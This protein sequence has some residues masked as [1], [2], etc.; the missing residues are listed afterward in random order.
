MLEGFFDSFVYLE[1]ENDDARLLLLGHFGFDDGMRRGPRR[2]EDRSIVR[3]S[4]H[5][6]RHLRCLSSNDINHA[7]IQIS[8]VMQMIMF[9][10]PPNQ[11]NWCAVVI[12]NKPNEMF[13]VARSLCW[14]WLISPFP[15]MF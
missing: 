6:D 8:L 1:S 4:L 7:I 13:I 15:E 3:M 5:V 12:S 2:R 11:M 14:R 9:L 10:P